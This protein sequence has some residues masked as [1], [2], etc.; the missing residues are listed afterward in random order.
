MLST[1]GCGEEKVSPQYSMH[2]TLISS[3]LARLEYVKVVSEGLVALLWTPMKQVNEISSFCS[4][5]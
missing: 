2:Y 1:L 4:K 5:K 3:V